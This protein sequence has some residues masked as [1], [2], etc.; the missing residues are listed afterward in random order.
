[1][2]CSYQTN[3]RPT[4]SP[5]EVLQFLLERTADNLEFNDRKNLYVVYQFDDGIRYFRAYDVT[6]GTYFFYKDNGGI[7]YMTSEEIKGI[8]SEKMERICIIN[9]IYV[10]AFIVYGPLIHRMRSNVAGITSSIGYELPP[11]VDKQKPRIRTVPR[12]L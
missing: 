12:N 4:S 9:D 10:D 5:E 11:V 8:T 3:D 7:K 1:M 2:N 6:K